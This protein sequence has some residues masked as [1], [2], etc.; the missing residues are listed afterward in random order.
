MGATL[1][2]RGSPVVAN[3][4]CTKFLSHA[5]VGMRCGCGNV[6]DLGPEVAAMVSALWNSTVAPA[7]DVSGS[8][9]KGERG[10]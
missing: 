3:A 10:L 1:S 8:G 5:D 2:K 7:N 4:F 6:N 9:C